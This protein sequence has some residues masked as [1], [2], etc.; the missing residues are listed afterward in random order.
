MRYEIS[1]S[2]FQA[3]YEVA[4]LQLGKAREVSVESN[5]TSQAKKRRVALVFVNIATS[6]F[7]RSFEFAAC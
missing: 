6:Q 7:A 2:V 1:R 3:L 4:T 5:A